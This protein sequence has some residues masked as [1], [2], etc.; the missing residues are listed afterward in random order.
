M[1]TALILSDT[2]HIGLAAIQVAQ[3]QDGKPFIAVRSNTEA[4]R[5]KAEFKL[6]ET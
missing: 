2:G 4:N 1:G 3:P 6:A 5:L